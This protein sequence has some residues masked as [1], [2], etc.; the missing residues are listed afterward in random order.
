M[1]AERWAK[2]LGHFR[3]GLAAVG[4][5]AG[6][7]WWVSV[8]WTVFLGS[9]FGDG[10]GI[11]GGSAFYLWTGQDART[12]AVA[13]AEVPVRPV[14]K[15]HASERRVPLEWDVF[16]Y[17][18]STSPRGTRSLFSVPL[19]LISLL[20]GGLAG[21]VWYVESRPEKGCCSTCGYDR[22]GGTRSERCPECGSVEEPRSEG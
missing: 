13:N 10:I 20:C 22:R 9:Q 4:V 5:L 7:L 8:W 17:S 3:N 19:W 15:W 11:K 21:F 12:W 18:S 1:K 2:R 6:V 14:W 16:T